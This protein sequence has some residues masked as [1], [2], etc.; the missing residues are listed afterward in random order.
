MGRWGLKGLR[1]GAYLTNHRYKVR[2]CGRHLSIYLVLS[3]YTATDLKPLSHQSSVLT[4]IPQHLR[5][6]QITEVRAVQSQTSLHQPSASPVDA[7]GSHRR[8]TDG[9]H[10]EHAPNKFHVAQ[11][12]SCLATD[13]SLTADPG[14]ACLIPFRYHTFVEIDHEIISRV[15]L[16]PFAESF[17]R[18]AVSN[19]LKYVHEVVGSTG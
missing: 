13:A 19:K 3:V 1:I 10:F 18:V 12:V 5:K 11:S 15:I 2:I 4:A 9:V 6:M 16:L 7:V 14:S 8:P 17:K